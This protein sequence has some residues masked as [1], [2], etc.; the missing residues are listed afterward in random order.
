MK[1]IVLIFLFAVSSIFA[2]SQVTIKIVAGEF[3]LTTASYSW[4]IKP[5]VD[6]YTNNVT[7][8]ITV[9]G[10]NSQR[11]FYVNSVTSFTVEGIASP[12]NITN[13]T[14]NLNDNKNVGGVSGGA[15][16]GNATTGNQVA[17]NMLTQTSLDTTIYFNRLDSA[18]QKKYYDSAYKYYTINKRQNDT[19]TKR[20]DSLLVKNFGSS[21]GSDSIFIKAANDSLGKI[22]KLQKDSSTFFLTKEYTRIFQDSI[23]KLIAKGGISDSN[24][25]KQ[26]NTILLDSSTLFVNKKLL[27]SVA[28]SN[29]LLR[30]LVKENTFKDSIN[31][32]LTEIKAGNKNAFDSIAEANANRRL[33]LKG[34]TFQDSINL[35]ITEIKKGNKNFLDSST[36]YLTLFIIDSLHKQIDTLRATLVQLKL[37]KY[38]DSTANE[39]LKTIK[40]S[41]IQAN[42]DRRLIATEATLQ[43]ALS[44]LELINKQ[45]TQIEIKGLLTDIKTNQIS[46]D[47][48]TQIVDGSGNTIESFGG[49]P[50]IKS[51]SE[52]GNN[53][54]TIFCKLLPKSGHQNYFFTYTKTGLAGSVGVFN[55]VDGVEYQYGEIFDVATGKRVESNTISNTGQYVVSIGAVDE[56]YLKTTSFFSANIDAVAS[57]TQAK[58]NHSVTVLDQSNN[59]SY[60]EKDG[61]GNLKVTTPLYYNIQ[62]G[63]D[64]GSTIQFGAISLSGQNTISFNV[65]G[66]WV[67]TL[68]PQL[69]IAG[70]DVTPRIYNIE[71]GA[72]LIGGVTA[73]GTYAIQ[74]YGATSSSFIINPFTSGAAT[75]SYLS[76]P[77]QFEFKTTSGGGGGLNGDIL[78]ASTAPTI[79]N[80]AQTVS[81]SPNGNVIRFGGNEFKQSVG[82][83]SSTQLA[84]AGV[85]TGAIESALG[86]PQI[87]ISLKNNQPITLTVRQYKDAAGVTEL[88]DFT[89]LPI[90]ILVPINGGLNRQIQIA[91]NYFRVIATNTGGAA[92]TNFDLDVYSGNFPD[93]PNLTTRGNLPIANN[94][95][96]GTVTATNA[97][98]ADAGTQRVVLATNQVVIPINNN[99]PT[100]INDITSSAITTSTTTAAVTPSNGVSFVSDINVT[101]VAGTTPNYQVNIEQ[102]YDAGVT[103]E[104]LYEYPAITVAGKYTSPRLPISGNRIRY[105]QTLTGTTPSFTRNITRDQCNDDVTLAYRTKAQSITTTITTGGTAQTLFTANSS[106]QGFEIQNNS[107]TDLRFS[108]GGTASANN[109]FILIAGGSYSSPTSRTTTMPI[110]IFGLTTGQQFTYI[111][112]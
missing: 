109:G 82:N 80:K 86:F 36:R 68:K 75:V 24:F 3:T 23:T 14:N 8:L 45:S 28:A 107:N 81:L 19:I 4:S 12:I 76:T 50:N 112:Y 64:I 93:N 30:N 25:I 13:I 101:A 79:A 22:V 34:I 6:V 89:G 18:M 111:Q 85:F 65:S 54:G 108:I 53:L 49:V 97:G 33:L 110:T 37:I 66:T 106:R 67:G 95:I 98:N 63:S 99:T 32:V 38:Y 90:T 105:V 88:F 20:F 52:N 92:T 48:K 21:S 84:A 74:T 102:S 94:E 10:T 17:L 7:G 5:V 51:P 91:G 55:T 47:Q 43:L 70:T 61:S 77:A 71:T 56:I 100:Q 83:I 60:A 11:Q 26:T 57:L 41:T 42:T 9:T 87:I 72:E 59:P 29:V 44:E 15:A 62:A 35:V 104:L 96:N 40:D 46:A 1:K 31:L 16:A 103:W 78:N 73:N 2:F 27:D 39:S 69:F 58:Y